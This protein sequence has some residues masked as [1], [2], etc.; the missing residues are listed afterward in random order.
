MEMA[1]V[2]YSVNAVLPIVLMTVLGYLLKRLGLLDLSFVS[3]GS[4]VAFLVAFPCSVFSSFNGVHLSEIFDLR[5]LLL[6]TL[7]MF[8][9]TA[10]LLLIVPLFVRERSVAASMVQGMVRSNM[11]IQGMPMLSL[12]YTGAELASGTF[13]LPFGVLANNITST[14]VFIVLLP[15]KNSHRIR[16]AIL[17]LLK[18]PLVIASVLGL[19]FAAFSWRL[20]TALNNTVTQ[21]G[22]AAAPLALLALGADFDISQCR[23]DLRYTLPSILVKLILVP[24]VATVAAVL[25]GVRGA[26]LCALMLFLG[27]SSASACYV[28]A[29]EMGGDAPVAGEIICLG[30]IL[31]AFTLAA[32]IYILK[33]LALI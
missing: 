4:K 32:G 20:P 17:P 5:L 25:L 28:M 13:M 27:S 21:L 15:Q 12:L 26:P 19:L 18:N 22:R 8:L 33:T 7:S 24:G 23:R 14:I 3:T 29:R 2:I 9:S 1:N 30:T 31:S 11:I 10:V 6:I 16:G